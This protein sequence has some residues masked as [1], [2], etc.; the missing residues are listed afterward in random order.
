MACTVHTLGAEKMDEGTA[1]TA[2]A[3]PHCHC[4][5]GGRAAGGGRGRC[6]LSGAGRA[7]RNSPN[8]FLLAARRGLTLAHVTEGLAIVWQSLA[9]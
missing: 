1:G 5:G 2:Q 3:L 8:C 6:A 4:R 7:S 9:G